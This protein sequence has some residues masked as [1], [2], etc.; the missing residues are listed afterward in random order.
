MT[1]S[2][3]IEKSTIE[4]S[5]TASTTG[6]AVGSI[7]G[8]DNPES[9]GVSGT[10]LYAISSEKLVELSLATFGLFTIIWSYQQWYQIYNGKPYR[11]LRSILMVTCLPFS[12]G[13]LY[14]RIAG[15]ARSEQIKQPQAI[16]APQSI[17]INW[18]PTRLHALFAG[19]LLMPVWLIGNGHWW[20]ALSILMTLLP[21]MVVNQ[22]VNK[23]HRK[24]N[25]QFGL[26][27]DLSALGWMTVVMGIVTW[28][29][30]LVY[31]AAE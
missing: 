3:V 15:I 1:D 29:T 27:Q 24:H 20:G 6:N 12:Q 10:R 17:K 7:G 21:N 18:S 14:H 4:Q 26:N 5:N 25:K 16:H 23:W 2:S 30:L 19:F 11:T 8:R 9:D 13:L 28:T 31:I 22:T